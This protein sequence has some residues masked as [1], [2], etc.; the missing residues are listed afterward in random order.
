MTINYYFK[1]EAKKVLW[2]NLKILQGG[3]FQ[4]FFF[5]LAFRTRLALNSQKWRGGVVKCEQQIE[6]WN[7][8][9]FGAD[10]DINITISSSTISSFF[11]CV[12][13][14][15]AAPVLPESKSFVT[16]LAKS[17]TVLPCNPTGFPKPT[18]KWK[19]N[20]LPLTNATSPKYFFLPSGSLRIL[21]L[22]LSD[23][24]LYTCEASNPLGDARHV[25]ELSVQGKDFFQ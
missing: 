25:V 21:R 22:A 3:H 13:C 23:I 9:N 12:L 8:C 14:S 2:A 16:A 11:L 15:T 6:R 1:L 7:M 18:I 5:G 10:I 17:W 24:G 4:G 20:G 19:R